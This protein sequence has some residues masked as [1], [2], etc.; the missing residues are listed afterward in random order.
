MST[1]WSQVWCFF[2]VSLF[3]KEG[4]MTFLYDGGTI[5]KFKPNHSFWLGMGTKY[6][7]TSSWSRHKI[8]GRRSNFSCIWCTKTTMISSRW[9][10]SAPRTCFFSPILISSWLRFRWSLPLTW[11]KWAMADSENQVVVAMRC[12]NRP[13]FLLLR[14]KTAESCMPA[15]T[16]SYSTAGLKLWGWPNW[17]RCNNILMSSYFN[18][19]TFERLSLF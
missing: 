7:S 15:R 2:T 11:A 12:S 9:K 13:L 8:T 1:K 10:S 16:K 6:T 17:N 18:M 4:P 19:A 3:M 5:A 14:S